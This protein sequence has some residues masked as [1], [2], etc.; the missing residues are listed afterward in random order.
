MSMDDWS[1]TKAIRQEFGF[2]LVGSISDERWNKEQRRDNA[3]RI[4]ENHIVR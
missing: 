3:V 1:W 4:S 2:R